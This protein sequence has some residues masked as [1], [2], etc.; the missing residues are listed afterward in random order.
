MSTSACAGGRRSQ[1][2]RQYTRRAANPS[3]KS[4]GNGRRAMSDEENRDYEVGFSKPPKHSQFKRG[5]SGNPKGRPKGIKN[6]KTELK[7][8]LALPVTV[9]H[10]KKKKTVSTAKAILLRIREKALGGDLRASD[11]LFV[12]ANLH[13]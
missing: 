10:G 5:R 8:A 3:M 6:F 7:E 13:L 12:Y 4:H 1:V 9:T 2:R 11:R